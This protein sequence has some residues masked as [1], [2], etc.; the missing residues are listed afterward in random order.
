MLYSFRPFSHKSSDD[1]FAHFSESFDPILD[2][3]DNEGVWLGLQFHPF[4]MH[5]AHRPLEAIGH[6]EPSGFNFDTSPL[7][8]QRVDPAKFHREF[9]NGIYHVHMKD[10]ALNLDGLSGTLASRLNFGLR[11]RSRIFRSLGHGSFNFEPIVRT[12]KH[13]CYR[14]LFRSSGKIARWSAQWRRPKPA[15][16]PRTWSSSHPLGRSTLS[17]RSEAA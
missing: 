9:R 15:G 13:T 2:V 6:C 1:G 12:L 3:F 5:T 14:G 11:V 4:E 8:G 17:L 7:N 10:A 16:S